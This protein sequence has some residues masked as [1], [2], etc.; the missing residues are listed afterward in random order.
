MVELLLQ[1]NAEIEAKDSFGRTPLH[2]AARRN[3]KGILHLLLKYS[4]DLR[5]Q[6]D[7]GKTP[8]QSA[9]EVGRHSQAE[10]LRAHRRALENPVSKWVESTASLRMISASPELDEKYDQT[11]TSADAI[12]WRSDIAIRHTL[13]RVEEMR[14]TL[15]RP[16]T[17]A[18]GTVT[19]T[20]Q[21]LP[22][23]HDDS[24]STDDSDERISLSIS[25]SHSHKSY[26][27]PAPSSIE[28]DSSPTQG[29]SQ[30]TL[31]NNTENTQLTSMTGAQFM[32]LEMQ[33]G[34]LT[35]TPNHRD[36]GL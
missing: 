7:N 4:A 14:T 13:T 35:E 2:V 1:N 24:W 19:I 15:R 6:D 17:S 10:L 21:G 34:G 33:Q 23:N 36:Q 11:A 26:G 5:A 25:Y 9:E 27:H 22:F 12:N 31:G 30:D 16:S 18:S 32:T 8:Q 28:E 3:D 29:F 20:S